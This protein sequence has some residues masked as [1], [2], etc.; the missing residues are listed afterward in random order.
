MFLLIIELVSPF[1]VG[2]L[3]TNAA[4]VTPTHLGNQDA[5]WPNIYTNGVGWAKYANGNFMQLDGY[6][7]RDDVNQLR[8]N[9]HAALA[10]GVELGGIGLDSKDAYTPPPG[11]EIH[12]IASY[13]V[14][15]M[16]TYDIQK[17]DSTCNGGS[18]TNTKCHPFYFIGDAGENND[19]AKFPNIKTA[20]DWEYFET[21][22]AYNPGRKKD[23]EYYRFRTAQIR[24]TGDD[25]LGAGG[26]P[27][28]KYDFK[29][30]KINTP[31]DPGGGGSGGTGGECPKP[32]EVPLRYEHELD[33]EVTRLDARTVD[34]NTDTHTDVY[35]K[36]EDFSGSRNAAKQEFKDYITETKAMKAE[37]ETLIAKWEAEKVAAQNAIA[38]LTSQRASCYATVVLPGDPPPNC[39]GYDSQIAT[40]TAIVA[41]KTAQIAAGKAMLPIYDEKVAL[42]EKE[43]DYIQSNE[44]KYSVLSPGVQLTYDGSNVSSLTASLSE[45]ETKRYTFPVWKPTAQGKDIMAQV[46]GSGPYQE[47]KYTNLKNRVA[48]S[49]GYNTSLGHVLHPNPT[50]NNWKD[51]TQYIAT[52]ETAACPPPNQ[53]FQ[54]QTIQGVVRTVNDNGVK[55]EIKETLTTSFTQLPRA[56]MRAGFGFEYELTTNYVNADKEPEPSDATGT[57]SVESYFPTTVRDFLPYTRGGAKPKFDVYGNVLPYGGVDE[58]YRV[59]MD[60]TVPVVSLT[61]I[62]PW[63][64]PPVAAEKF[65]GN[66]FTMNNNDHL[67]HPERN[68]A[69]TLLTTDKDG[70]ALHKWYTN[71]TDPDGPYNYR[72]RTYD[73]GV[74]H[75][76]TC[77][78]G[79]VEIKGV[80]I[81]DPNGDDDYVKRA[82]TPANP[83]P[84]GVGWNWDGNVSL[85]TNLSDWYFNW[86]RTPE[87]L[88]ASEYRAMFYLTPETMKQIN[89]YT[90]KH[91]DLKVGESVLDHVYVPTH[92]EGK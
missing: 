60:T 87:E 72:V 27:W 23:M 15:R 73:A 49:L 26:K 51:T 12:S 75:L 10:P 45:G 77:H 37:C 82:I 84:S 38:S 62:K 61:G 14:Y 66:M 35:V 55:R 2:G 34:I 25:G 8:A 44:S 67:K 19:W 21:I 92:K 5:S 28:L 46:N 43:L 53:V 18:E 40:Q 54:P 22:T 16:R 39:S 71:F 83:F 31:P 9:W 20:S 65:S 78:N 7:I 85:L 29:I 17:E 32:N 69:E 81:G 4:N 58:G 1:F 91:P 6:F 76:N 11:Y 74:N 30:V 52:Y 80:I 88:P 68:F 41:E 64:L 56:Q 63:I 89:E 3:E 36:R 70:K 42:A 90:T 86:F 57:K 47:F 50:S 24:K 48:K 59:A 33:L 79:T 13:A